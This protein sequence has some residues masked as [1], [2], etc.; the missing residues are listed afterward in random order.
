[1]RPRDGVGLNMGDLLLDHCHSSLTRLRLLLQL[2]HQVIGD[3]G[4]EGLL[5]HRVHLLHMLL[6][7]GLLEVLRECGLH[8]RVTRRRW[9]LSTVACSPL[10][11]TLHRRERIEDI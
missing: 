6:N 4:N 9:T 5:G 10:G 2:G 7:L 8:R 3:L 1:M 11:V